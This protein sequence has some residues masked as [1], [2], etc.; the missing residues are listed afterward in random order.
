MI[1]QSLDG[2]IYNKKTCYRSSLHFIPN[3]S[4]FFY[5]FQGGQGFIKFLKKI[6]DIEQG[7]F[8]LDD[9]NRFVY[10]KELKEETRDIVVAM[11]DFVYYNTETLE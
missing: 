7:Y 9:K 11:F 6:K 5:K 3:E 4:S 10:K 8:G 1:V 2:Q